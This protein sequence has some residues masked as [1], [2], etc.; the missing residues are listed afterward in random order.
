[1]YLKFKRLYDY[2]GFKIPQ[3]SNY[4]DACF[5]VFWNPKDHV[6]YMILRHGENHKFE[7]GIALEIPHG[8]MLLVLDRSSVAGNKNLIVGAKVL[9]PSY[10]GNVMIDLHAIGNT[11]EG[12]YQQINKGDKI[13]QIAIIPII[14]AQLEET[15]EIYKNQ[16]TISNRGDGGFGSTGK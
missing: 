3:K 8:F 4:S 12:S 9:D 15:Y 7:T 10:S 2:E 11:F 13:A 1:M 16:I 14:H 6:P 5:D